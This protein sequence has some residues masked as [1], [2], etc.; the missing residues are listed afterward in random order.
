[1]K[2]P[3]RV[4]SPQM[5]LLAEIDDYEELTFVRR[6]HTVGEF[7]LTINSYKQHTDLLQRQHLIMLG[8]DTRKVGMIT[9]REI[10]VSQKGKAAEQWFVKG[11]TLEGVVGQRVIVPP[12]AAEHDV[13]SGTAE[14][15]MKHYLSRHVIDP[16]DAARKMEMATLAPDQSRGPLLTWQSRYGNLEEELAKISLLSGLGWG[17][18]LDFSLMRWVFDVYE[19]RDVTWQQTENP[20]VI[21]SVEFDS[22]KEAHYIDSIAGFR[23]LAYVGGQGEGVARAIQ[24]VGSTAGLDRFESFIDARDVES[25]AELIPR[26]EQALYELRREEK[27]EAQV[28]E[29]SPFHYEEDWKLGDIVTVQNR[30]WGVTLDSRITEVREAYEDSGFKLEVT[31]GHSAPTLLRRL[32]QELAQMSAE[33]RK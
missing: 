33:V 18:H 27:F 2:K 21:F 32:K 22:L 3:I 8:A 16:D 15:V 5:D 4:L 13:A 28:L 12:V 25:D 20:P 19:G 9:H 30:R 11:I 7:E 1:M 14:T 17:V 26:G 10:K 24:E 29:S 6:W 31:F 23:N